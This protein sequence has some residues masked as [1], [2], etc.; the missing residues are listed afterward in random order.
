MATMNASL[1]VDPISEPTDADLAE[2]WFLDH[3]DRAI[4]DFV[5]EV[6]T[7]LPSDAA[8]ASAI[9]AEVRDRIWYDPHD[10][11]SDPAGYRASAVLDGAQRW[12]VP[13]AVLVSAA[14]R[15]VGIPARLGFADVRNHLQSRLLAERMGTDVFHWHGYSMLWI[16]GCWRKASP[17]FNTEL[18]LRFGTEPLDFDGSADALLHQHAGDGRRHME[19]LVDRGSYTDLPLDTI[20]ADFETLYGSAVVTSPVDDAEFRPA[21]P[22]PRV[23]ENP[24]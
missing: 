5:D 20:F 21:S 13:K 15:A 17:A 24:S 9:F 6:A 4:R 10:V 14:A 18:C 11:T 19:Y 8:R 7:Q 22:R 16:D 2:T 1:S 23:G 3:A 12:C